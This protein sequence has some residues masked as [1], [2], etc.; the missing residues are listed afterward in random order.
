MGEGG[1]ARHV[2]SGSR[3]QQPPRSA[4]PPRDPSIINLNVECAWWATEEGGEEAVVGWGIEEGGL[5]HSLS[6]IASHLFP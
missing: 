2:N 5:S 3:N 4:V 1:G 6:S